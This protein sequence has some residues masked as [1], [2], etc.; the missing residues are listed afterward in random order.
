M[1]AVRPAGPPP[2]MRQSRIGWSMRS[3]M[4]CR[5][6][7]SPL[8]PRHELD[9]RTVWLFVVRPDGRC[10]RLAVR[11]HPP[12]VERATEKVDLGFGVASDYG[13]RDSA[14]H[15]VHRHRRSWAERADGGPRDCGARDPRWRV[16]ASG[17]GRRPCRCHARQPEAPTMTFRASVL[18]LYPDMF[19]GPLGASLAGKALGDGIWT[20]D[21]TNIRDLATDKHRSVDDT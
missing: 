6:G 20:L 18:T 14:G 7:C 8:A 17:L 11:H 4:D 16:H 9:A 1:A 2:M 21:A 13:R 5:P 12:R 3:P 19:P 10:A 15:P